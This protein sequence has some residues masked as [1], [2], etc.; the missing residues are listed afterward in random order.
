MITK[1]AG[2]N[3]G[4]L[5]YINFGY[6]QGGLQYATNS[7]TVHGHANA[8]GAEAVGAAAYITHLH[9]V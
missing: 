2:P 3:P 6:P 1:Y 5:K 8:A 4:L 9:M 7:S